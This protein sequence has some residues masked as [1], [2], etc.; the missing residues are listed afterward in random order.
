VKRNYTFISLLA[1][2][3]LVFAACGGGGGGGT[4]PVA[5][6]TPT[7]MPPS[8]NPPP[9]TQSATCPTSGSAAASTGGSSAGTLEAIRA[10]PP[11]SRAQHYVPGTVAVSYAAGARVD[12][13]DSVAGDLRGARTDD[14]K[15][16]ALNMRVRVFTVDPARVDDAIAKLRSVPGVQS[17]SRVAY[18]QKMQITSN[19]P[20][21]EGFGAPAPL[22]ETSTTPGQWDMHVMHADGG[23]SAVSSAPPVTGVPIAIIDTGVDVN[24]PELAGGKIIRTECFVTFPSG[25]AQT[26]GSFVT[27]TDGHGTNV[28]GIADANTGNGLGFAS[29]AFAAPMLAYRIFPTEPSG[30]CSG[31][32]PPAQ[33]ESSTLDEATAINDAVAHGAK[34]INLSLGAT[35]PC[36]TTDAEFQ[37]VEHAISAGVVVVAAAGNEHT[38]ALDCPAADPGV[39][40][41]GA[42]AIDDS[43]SPAKEK[44]ASY[45]NYV[46]ST[47][48][49]HY[50]VAPG[51]DPSG[52][53]D[54]NDLHWIEN[55]YSST[56][57]QHGTC[58]PDFQSTSSTIDCR[59][60]IA[61]TSQATPHVVGVASLILAVRPSYTPAQVAAAICN[62]AT[63]ISDSKQG[64]G[65]VDAA[66][67][68]NYAKSH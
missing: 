36:S 43:V 38:N 60:L 8:G 27:D 67:A 58:T 31:S 7:P 57:V 56:A 32:N 52:S 15:L 2:S 35:G 40:A 29:V 63:D 25:T 21:F 53:N 50:V 41:V 47:G 42:T 44:V 54:S 48:S 45:S 46:T 39:I 12:E 11:A 28:A 1:V 34:V 62:S 5:T 20:Y 37:A 17:A 66:A 16:S 51:G 13:I 26:S 24:H 33:C 3:A 18:R 65:R 23:W 55:I 59:I 22:F 30:G 4:P 64:C 49:G 68:V 6:I 10:V 61:G 19:D 9:T 14:L